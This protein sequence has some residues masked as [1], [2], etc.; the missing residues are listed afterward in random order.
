[1]SLSLLKVIL[2]GCVVINGAPPCWKP[3]G[4]ISP[5]CLSS[6][7]PLWNGLSGL[8]GF[9]KVVHQELVSEQL[10]DPSAQGKLKLSF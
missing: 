1:V 5:R 8:G 4:G 2:K 3:L 9:S 6:N 7:F 10:T